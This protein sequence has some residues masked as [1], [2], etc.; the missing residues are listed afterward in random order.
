[1][2]TANR[3]VK[4]ARRRAPGL[5]T[6]DVS[7]IEDS[8]LR[9]PGPGEFRVKTAFVS[10]DPAMRGWINEGRSYVP[11]V[12]VGDVMRGY[13]VGRVDASNHPEFKPGD[14]VQGLSGAQQY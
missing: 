3:Q 6:R 7:A 5:V 10:L 13:A 14:A 12:A 9:E 11:P 1:M 8:P 4:L 2:A